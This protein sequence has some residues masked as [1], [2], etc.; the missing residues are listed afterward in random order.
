M[1]S[2]PKGAVV[3]ELD[4][5]GLQTKAGEITEDDRDRW[6]HF[7]R[8]RQRSPVISPTLT[9]SDLDALLSIG[10]NPE[11]FEAQALEEQTALVEAAAQFHSSALP[12][13]LGLR[14]LQ[15]SLTGEAPPPFP[16]DVGFGLP[17]W[18]FPLL[19]ETAQLRPPAAAASRGHGAALLGEIDV[20]ASDSGEHGPFGTLYDLGGPDIGHGASS[21]VTFI[22]IPFFNG[23][24]YVRPRVDVQGTVFIV[25]H[26]HWYTET[27]ADL[28]LTL[29]CAI[30]QQFMSQ[31]PP[32]TVVHEHKDHKSS[33]RYWIQNSYTP[34][35]ST[36]VI[37]G[38]PV[39]ITV[40]ASLSV[41][42]QSDHA[43]A[44][45]DFASDADHYIRVPVIDLYN[46]P[47]PPL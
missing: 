17:P 46:P 16:E 37:A 35:A 21:S 12:A 6:A 13:E 14:T 15:T 43:V 10:F 33:A 5:E 4:L 30:R 34:A 25:S 38:E 39:F 36:K 3:G 45:A 47:L 23:S 22:Y 7:A 40:I 20:E 11:N 18:L 1:L 29:G 2:A 24:L 27:W 42:G 44:S 32:L 8:D 19:F 28:R 26:G 9:N 31:S 41:W